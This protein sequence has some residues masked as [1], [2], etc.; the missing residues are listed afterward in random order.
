MTAQHTPEPWKTDDITE[1]S[2]RWKTNPGTM[3]DTLHDLLPIL[4]NAALY[5]GN[6]YTAAQWSDVHHIVLCAIAKAEGR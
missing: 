6:T 1:P 4:A 5:G 3:L 2:D